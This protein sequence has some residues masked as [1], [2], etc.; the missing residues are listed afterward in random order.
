MPGMKGKEDKM[1]SFLFLMQIL[2]VR[3]FWFLPGAFHFTPVAQAFSQLSISLLCTGRV[4]MHQP[5]NSK[6]GGKIYSASML[7][8][9]V[10]GSSAFS[11]SACACS[12]P[13][14]LIHFH[15]YPKAKV[16]AFLGRL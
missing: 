2:W 14:V 10:S 8:F 16:T 15:Y 3:I 11:G 5:F 4:L 1:V 13:A 9:M 6:Q 12:L 7:F